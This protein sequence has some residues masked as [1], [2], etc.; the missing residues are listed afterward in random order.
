MFWLGT[1]SAALGVALYLI[2]HVVIESVC[3]VC[4]GTYLVNFGLAFVAFMALLRAGG[5]PLRSLREDLGSVRTARGA[6]ALYAAGLAVVLVVAWIVVPPYWRIE[7]ST[8]PGGLPVGATAGGHPWIGGEQPLLEIEEFSDYQCPHCR[9]GHDE[10]RRIVADFPGKV[11]LVHRNFPLDQECN[12]ALQRPFHPYACRYARLAY[13]AMR[14]GR[15]WEAN[16]FLFSEGR[17]RVPVAADEL[18]GALG[19]D[20]DKLGAC[21]AGDEARRAIEHDLEAGRALHIRGTPTFVVGG[22]IY[23]G[24][25]PADVISAALSARPGGGATPGEE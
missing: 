5:R 14:Q 13:C 25:V 22:E 15:F 1:A 17:R 9:R 2:S 7:A 12:S 18:A 24:R 21:V 16:D 23:P 4:A 10:M 19:L 6:F 3:I 8:G 11:R 20:A